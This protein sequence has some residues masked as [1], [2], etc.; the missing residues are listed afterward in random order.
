MK[1]FDILIFGDSITYGAY[2]TKNGGW[3][4]RLKL[5]LENDK[6]YY[7]NIFNLGIPGNTT[8]NIKERFNYE[9]E[10]RYNINSNTII[11]FSIGINDSYIIN[12]KNNVSLTD[13]K[14]NIID[15]INMAKIYTK[16]ILFI[17]LSNVNESQVNPIPW[18]S[19]ICYLNK[20]IFKFDKEL[21]NI[22]TKNNVNYLNVFK[23][24][25]MNDLQ[26]GLHPNNIGHKKLYKK[27]LHYIQNNFLSK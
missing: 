7:F 12:Q 1:D 17:G 14:N 18:N 16:N 6:N 3:V 9:C 21:E 20:E 15:L 10:Q 25:E 27:I 2:D 5:F 23:L 22:C 24:L 13:F 19:N 11:I 8:I 4:N 26:D